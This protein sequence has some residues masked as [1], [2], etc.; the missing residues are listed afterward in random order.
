MVVGGGLGLCGGGGGGGLGL[1][2]GG[3]G[4]VRFVWWCWGF[5]V[6][7]SNPHWPILDI[8]PFTVN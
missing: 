4:G 2:G 1:C 7:K 5:F 6:E 3:G 8:S